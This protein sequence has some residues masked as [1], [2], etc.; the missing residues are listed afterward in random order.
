MA[1]HIVKLLEDRPE[2]ALNEIERAA[3]TAHIQDCADCRKAYQAFRISSA[4]LRR[5]TEEAVEP[6]PFFS[7]RVLAALNQNGSRQPL[8]VATMWKAARGIVVSMVAFVL[9]LLALT[10]YEREPTPPS[11]TL[12]AILDQG[13]YSPEW[14]LPGN[15]TTPNGLTNSQVLMTVYEPTYT[16]GEYK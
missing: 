2:A 1:D 3:I 6:S 12:E 7:T 4:L 9:L 15:G 14:V 8:T 16:Y 5:R 10:S 11:D 13:L